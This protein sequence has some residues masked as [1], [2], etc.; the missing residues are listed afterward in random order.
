MSNFIAMA[1]YNLL[2]EITLHYLAK[3]DSF[4]ALAKEIKVKNWYIH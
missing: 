2:N 3:S 1:N 4:T